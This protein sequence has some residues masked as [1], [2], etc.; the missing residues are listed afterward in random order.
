MEKMFTKLFDTE[1]GRLLTWF[2]FN[3][4]KTKMKRKFEGTS[5]VKWYHSKEKNVR[6]YPCQVNVFYTHTKLKVWISIFR[7]CQINRKRS[8]SV[9][10]Q[11]LKSQR[12]SSILMFS[13]TYQSLWYRLEISLQTTQTCDSKQTYTHTYTHTHPYTVMQTNTKTG[14]HFGL[15]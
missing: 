3:Q 14:A 7:Q 1:G 10:L 4:E 12:T 2:E 9:T 11:N 15:M 13:L 8:I 5:T 6:S